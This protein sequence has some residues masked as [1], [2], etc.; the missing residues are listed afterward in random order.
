MIRSIKNRLIRIILQT[1]ITSIV[2]AFVFVTLFDVYTFR[3][4]MIETAILI[5][6]VAGDYSVTELA[7]NN[8]EESA[9]TLSRL[10]IIPNLES[11]V[12]YDMEGELF[13]SFSPN[14]A[15]APPPRVRVDGNPMWEFTGGSLQVI[16]PI[17]HNQVNYGIICV[18]L[19]TSPLFAKI[20]NHLAVLV[21]IAAIVVFVSIF[22]ALKLQKLISD[23][24]LKLADT[25][26]EI[27]S[28]GD[29]SIRVE[30]SGDDEIADLCGAFNSMLDQVQNRQKERDSAIGA[31][32]ESEGRFRSLIE[33]SND[34]LFVLENFRIVYVNPRFTAFM[35]YSTDEVTSGE[36]NVL[37][38]VSP[39]IQHKIANLIRRMKRGDRIPNQYD[40]RGITRDGSVIDFEVNFSSIEWNGRPAILG[41]LR[42]ITARKKTEEEL[43][44]KQDEL[45][46]VR[47][48]LQNIIDSMPSLLIGVDPDNRVIQWNSEAFR[49]TGIRQE[50]A[51]GKN[52][53]DV[54]P[55]IRAYIDMIRLAMMTGQPQKEE[56]IP[57]QSGNEA[58]FM[59]LMVY[60]LSSETG[61]GAVIRVDDVTAR[62]MIEQMMLQT[63][64]M[65]SVGGL[66]AGMAHEINNPLGGILM[67][68]QN[69]FRRISPGLAKNAE[70]AK[71]AGTT[72][73][74][75]NRY[76]EIRGLTSLIGGIQEMGERAS[77]IVQNML[78]FSRRS[79]SKITLVDLR[80]LL[81][82]TLELAANDY[83]LKKK[84]DFRHIEIIRE[85]G[86]DIPMVPCFPQEI[87]QVILN[88]VK[89]AAQALSTLE[90]AEKPDHPHITLRLLKLEDSVQI[91]VGDNGPGM[92]EKTKGRVFEPFFTTKKPGE[93][94]GLGLSVSCHIIINNHKGSI[95]LETSPG[96]GANFIMNLPL[97]RN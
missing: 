46:S 18:R 42:D 77:G 10:R 75:I 63:E 70:A 25:A 68:V 87:E 45:A 78:N 34:P 3:R 74:G 57:V 51:L 14:P 62:V 28:R 21:F 16:R 8:R 50:D 65:M 60:P 58:R 56:R 80:E 53:V 49:I 2:I 11:V 64:K 1:S 54:Y 39:D 92:D 81:D 69:F 85:Y 30:R 7:F 83:D 93:G 94:T 4:D 38:L 73:E 79:E 59:D 96:R 13:S 48:Y 43:R 6:R 23:P 40:L 12:I 24:I 61:E 82:K 22:F 17:S 19:S 15:D 91:E 44:K 72:I 97:A 35:G 90:G 84:Y 67:G 5:S 26:K 20:F 86:D 52:V 32:M 29:Y 89:N 55:H 33:Q 95:R 76:M 36:F 9:T 37:T 27:S 88:L 31:L 71:E 66:A 47:I 41:M